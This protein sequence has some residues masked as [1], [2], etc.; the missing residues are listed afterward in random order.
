MPILDERKQE[1]PREAKQERIEILDEVKS[2]FS[3]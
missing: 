2:E 3:N 1:P